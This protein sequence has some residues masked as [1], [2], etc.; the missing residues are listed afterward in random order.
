MKDQLESFLCQKL[1]VENVLLK[2]P[3][4]SSFGHFSSTVAFNLAKEK[5]QNP[6]QIAQ[7]IANE[8]SKESIFKDVQAVGAYINFFVSDNFIDSHINAVLQNKAFIL[9]PVSAEKI[10]LEFVSANPT[11]PLHIGHARGAI[12]GDALQRIGKFLGKNITS[13][14]YVNDAGN[15]MLLLGASIVF[16]AQ[17]ILG[18]A[19]QELQESYKGEYIQDVAQEAINTFGKE[20]F[21]QNLSKND[22]QDLCTWAKDKML[23]LIKNSLLNN[24]IHFDNFVSEKSLY[25]NWSNVFEILEKNNATYTDQTG[26]IW[27]KS[28]QKNDAKDR[29]IVRETLEPTYLAGDIIYHH[30]KLERGFEKLINIWGADHHGYVARLKAAIDFLGFNSQNLEVLLSQMVA[31]L[32]NG[33]P[34]KMSKRAGNFVLMDDVVQEIGI[35]ALRFMFLTKRADTHLEFDINTLKNQDSSNP[36]FYIQY[37]HARI[38]SVFARLEKTPDFLQTKLVDLSSDEQDLLILAASLPDV[39]SDAFDSRNINLVTDFLMNLASSFHK[40]YTQNKIIDSPKE[41]M[42][43]KIIA[44][45]AFSLKTALETLGIQAPNK[46]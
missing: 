4:Q 29:V 32:K 22:S 26:K 13:E 33:E 21:A 19:P 23:D 2:R 18:Q 40:F 41:A 12:Y 7:Q 16:A 3:K 17:N 14:Y 46:M 1:G 43:L 27:L 45:V 20:F 8:L 25:K 42:L 34:Y 44:F 39:L 30:N 11:G 15:Q 6:Q 5:R 10:L 28:S 9:K 31:L 36:V 24:G 38:M 37:A 35:D